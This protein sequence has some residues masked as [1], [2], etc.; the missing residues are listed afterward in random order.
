MPVPFSSRPASLLA[1]I[2]SATSILAAAGQGQE[3][4]APPRAASPAG[5]GQDAGPAQ[6]GDR[7]LVRGREA[8]QTG[9]Y[10]DALADLLWC[11]D[12]CRGNR[13]FWAT[14]LGPVLDNL[15]ELA[16]VHPPAHAALTKRREQ[17]DQAVREGALGNDDVAELLALCEVLGQSA[18]SVRAFDA[19]EPHHGREELAFFYAGIRHELWRQRRYKTLIEGRPNPEERLA[20]AK[21]AL[22]EATRRLV[23]HDLQPDPTFVNHVVA[24]VCIDVEARIALHEKAAME[25]LLQ[26][27]LDFA[28]EPRTAARLIAHA[29]R[30]GDDAVA[31]AITRRA[32]AG[33]D[34]EAREPFDRMLRQARSELTA[35]AGGPAR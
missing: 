26:A 9:R 34:A 15:G 1:V 14:R 18:A 27:T 13:T 22:R 29:E 12:R 23:G 17:Q 24:D 35:L 33:M 19:I 25:E 32:T 16:K 28:P 8:M 4:A 11:F 10:D 7:R 21:T 30:A 31:K 20:T 3:P 6:E 5:A 2:V